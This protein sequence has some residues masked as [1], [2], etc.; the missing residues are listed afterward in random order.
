VTF[1]ESYNAVIVLL[2]DN[3]RAGHCMQIGVRQQ[4]V[5][6]ETERYFIINLT[7]AAG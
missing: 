3:L 5:L 1:A 6:M 4:K 7:N 2:T